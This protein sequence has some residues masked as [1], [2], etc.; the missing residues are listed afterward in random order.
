MLGDDVGMIE[1][2]GCFEKCARR[3]GPLIVR[4][5]KRAQVE[6][7]LLRQLGPIF[8]PR[9]LEAFLQGLACLGGLSKRLVQPSQDR[10]RFAIVGIALDR[11]LADGDS[12]GATFQRNQD[13]Y[14]CAINRRG[15][16][17]ERGRFL[18]CLQGFE[19]PVFVLTDQAMDKSVHRL[20]PVD[21]SLGGSLLRHVQLGRIERSDVLCA[22]TAGDQERD[23]SRKRQASKHGSH[24]CD[25]RNVAEKT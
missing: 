4:L 17:I 23:G 19:Q 15:L 5:V 25:A 11:F 9:R 3:A 20:T 10:A 1:E 6:I 12:L 21:L 7:H 18:E 16:R 14:L 22:K 8:E 24:P 2:H 13:R